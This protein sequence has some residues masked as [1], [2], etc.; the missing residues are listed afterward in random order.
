MQMKNGTN[1]AGNK[2]T[3]IQ[4]DKDQVKAMLK[5]LP[6]KRPPGFSRDDVKLLT[7]EGFIE[8]LQRAYRCAAVPQTVS[9]IIIIAVATFLFSLLHLSVMQQHVFS[10]CMA[11]CIPDMRPAK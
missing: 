5:K 2:V 9:L 6:F 1:G 10:G 3:G 4:Q 7:Y 11:T 8:L